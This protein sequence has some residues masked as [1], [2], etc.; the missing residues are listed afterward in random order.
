MTTIAR[1]AALLALTGSLAC[2]GGGASLPAPSPERLPFAEKLDVD[3]AKMTKT[4][5]GVYIRDLE[6][7]TGPLIENGQSVSVRYVG[8]L[9]NGTE[10]DRVGPG[11]KPISFKLGRR[12]VIQGW[13]EG[14]MGMRVGGKRQLVV[15]PD[16]GYGPERSGKIPGDAT[17]VFVV[18]VVS[19][20]F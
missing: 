11:D 18:E 2:A 15:P 17:L 3:F 1:F 19:A 16:M 7:G 8:S 6:L 10:F 13:D 14:M 12:Q 9:N 20:K 4:K 5:G